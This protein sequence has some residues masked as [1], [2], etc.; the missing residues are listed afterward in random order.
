M[1]KRKKKKCLPKKSPRDPETETTGADDRGKD[2][3]RVDA[4]I[5]QIR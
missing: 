1:G 4:L 3:E 5:D 2:A